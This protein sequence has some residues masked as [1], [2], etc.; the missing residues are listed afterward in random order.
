VEMDLDDYIDKLLP[1]DFKLTHKK[2]KY[3]TIAP[4]LGD[5]ISLG[6][7]EAKDPAS[8]VKFRA[9]VKGLIVQPP[10]DFDAWPD[11]LVMLVFKKIG[12]HYKDFH[13]KNAERLGLVPAQAK[14]R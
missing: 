3:P 6:S 5:I 11:A 4:T 13:S 9:Y 14:T 7:L 12:E 10:P 8:L 2:K 1:W